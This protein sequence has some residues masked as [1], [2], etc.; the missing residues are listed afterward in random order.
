[1]SHFYGRLLGRRNGESTRCGDRTSGLVAIGNGWNIGGRVELDNDSNDE[2]ILTIYITS[3]S[4]GG[5]SI[6]LGSFK[7][8]DNGF[9]NLDTQQLLT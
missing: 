6:K 2:D 5:S 8:V 9:L 3:G 4:G 1:M 7:K